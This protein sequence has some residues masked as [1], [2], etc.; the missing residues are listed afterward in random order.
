MLASVGGTSHARRYRGSRCVIPRSLVV[1]DVLPGPARSTP[2]AARRDRAAEGGTLPDLAAPGVALATWSVVAPLRA[3]TGPP[4]PSSRVQALSPL[5]YAAD[6]SLM[7]A[8]RLAAQTAPAASLR[9]RQ[10]QAPPLCRC[11]AVAGR[12]GRR[13]STGLPERVRSQSGNGRRRRTAPS[14][15]SH[16]DGARSK[17][18]RW[19]ASLVLARWPRAALPPPAGPPSAGVRAE[20]AGRSAAVCRWSPTPFA[21]ILPPA[22]S[23]LPPS[24]VWPS[25][26]PACSRPDT[27]ALPALPRRRPGEGGRSCAASRRLPIQIRARAK[28]KRRQR[29]NLRN[30]TGG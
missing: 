27:L 16:L 15:S 26:P 17:V 12:E 7:L 11:R 25:S 23:S 30:Q 21:L 13:V 5:R 8:R 2:S 29:R 20:R 3:V 4:L 22:A 28:R 1:G 6:H 18:R 24:A 19:A 10:S 14:S 9:P